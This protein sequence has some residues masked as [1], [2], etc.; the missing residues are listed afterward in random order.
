MSGYENHR[1]K[2]MHYYSPNEEAV[3]QWGAGEWVWNFSS[4]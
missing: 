2:R 4:T 1:R 3:K